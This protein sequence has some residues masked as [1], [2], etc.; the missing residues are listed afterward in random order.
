MLERLELVIECSEIFVELIEFLEVETCGS[1]EAA[2]PDHAR[3]HD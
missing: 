3:D 1:S 2:G